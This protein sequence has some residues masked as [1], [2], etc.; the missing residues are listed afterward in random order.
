MAGPARLAVGEGVDAKAAAVAVE[1]YLCAWLPLS[2]D[3]G[4]LEGEVVQDNGPIRSDPTRGGERHHDIGG[5]RHDDLLLDEMF[6]NP[7]KRRHIQPRFPQGLSA[8]QALA[9]QWIDI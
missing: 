7:A 9:K 6:P 2:Q 4:T 5:T 3:Q 8:G 1:R